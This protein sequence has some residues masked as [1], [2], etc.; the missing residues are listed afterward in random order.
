M[1][2]YSE[3]SNQSS[4]PSTLLILLLCIS[5]QFYAAISIDSLP[6]AV[7]K[8]IFVGIPIAHIGFSLKREFAFDMCLGTTRDRHLGLFTDMIHGLPL[9][10]WFRIILLTYAE[11]YRNH[12]LYYDWP[13]VIKTVDDVV[14][15]LK[16]PLIILKRL[17]VLQYS[18]HCILD[19][20]LVTL[21]TIMLSWPGLLYLWLSTY[22]S[23]TGLHPLTAHLRTP[24]Q[25]TY[26]WTNIF[27]LNAGYNLERSVFPR[28][29]WCRIPQWRST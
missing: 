29:T 18:H 14:I 9:F 20:V 13:P 24:N 27:N 26:D 6:N 16:R 19:I 2:S 4:Q 15:C 25:S 5:T 8:L 12:P 17:P 22:L 28:T 3:Q 21:S 1:S 10:E 7:I 23:L 11:N